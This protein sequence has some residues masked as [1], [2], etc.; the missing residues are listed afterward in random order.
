[1]ILQKRKGRE[2][3]D[4]SLQRLRVMLSVMRTTGINADKIDSI[5]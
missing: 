1:M 2:D 4:D 5:D 3:L